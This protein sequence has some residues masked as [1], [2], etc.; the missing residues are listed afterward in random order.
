MLL[1]N[2]LFSQKPTNKRLNQLIPNR[3]LL[4]NSLSANA[5]VS[6]ASLENGFCWPVDVIEIGSGRGPTSDPTAIVIHIEPISPCSPFI[7]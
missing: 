4:K 7:T 2:V 1:I 3:K 6:S 5:S